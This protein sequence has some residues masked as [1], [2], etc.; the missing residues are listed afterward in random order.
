MQ[1]IKTNDK[2]VPSNT[3]GSVLMNGGITSSFTMFQNMFMNEVRKRI[4][5]AINDDSTD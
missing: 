3:K 4:D 1:E 5:K 2:G